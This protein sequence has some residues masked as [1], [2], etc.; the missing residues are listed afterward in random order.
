MDQH[1]PEMLWTL[2][3]FYHQISKYIDQIYECTVDILT[4][5]RIG[6]E[7]KK[8]PPNSFSSAI[9]ANVRISPQNFL[10]FS[11]NPFTTLV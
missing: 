7:G 8:V 3:F 1:I 5:F 2:I 11:F 10:T 4:L 9:S 6:E